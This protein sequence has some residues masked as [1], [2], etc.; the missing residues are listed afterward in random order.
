MSFL[1]NNYSSLKLNS[2]LKKTHNIQEDVVISRNELKREIKDFLQQRNSMHQK[3]FDTWQKTKEMLQELRVTDSR[4]NFLTH[5]NSN[6][7]VSIYLSN[8]SSRA[9]G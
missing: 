6:S 3:T 7:K 5:S 9:K 2:E 8:G 4:E 1:T